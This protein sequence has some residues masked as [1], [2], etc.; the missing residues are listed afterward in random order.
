MSEK[1]RIFIA[2]DEET[3]LTSL[4]KLFE[5]SG[6]EVD[7]SRESKNVLAMVKA[8]KPHVIL[9]DLLMPGMGGFE[10]C[11]LLNKDEDTQKVPIIII[12]A[13]ADDVD[14]KK[15]FKMG[16]VGYFTKPFDYQKLLYEV[17]KAIAYK[18]TRT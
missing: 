5:L 10:I 11:E 13:L 6:F 15:A 7:T 9:L 12:S 8:F 18:E 16:V 2:D 3:I 4:K 17:N 14:I 1:K